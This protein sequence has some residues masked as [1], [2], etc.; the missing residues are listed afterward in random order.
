M[1]FLDRLFG[2]NQ[3]HERKTPASPPDDQGQPQDQPLTDEQAIERYKYM[4]RT[5]SPEAIEQAHEEAFAKLTPEQRQMVLDQLA[6]V[7]PENERSTNPQD[8]RTLARMATRAEVRQPGTL[9]NIFGKPLSTPDGTTGAAPSTAAPGYGNYGGFGY[10]S[11][12][13]GG[14]G[15]SLLSSI[16]GAFIGT[17]IADSLFGNFAYDQGYSDGMD[18]NAGN[19]QPPDTNT[20]GNDQDAG[21]ADTQ[22]MDYGTSDAGQQDWGGDPGGADFGGGDF[23]GDFG[24]GDF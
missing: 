20:D 8:P 24:G 17:A 18:Q 12:M 16:A 4:L 15:G 7:T 6:T 2:R 22:T 9:V 3:P 14:F 1:G 13:M 21:A 23:G 19:D 5:A 11:G 10:G